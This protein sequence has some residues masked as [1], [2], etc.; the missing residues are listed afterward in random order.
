MRSPRSMRS[1]IAQAVGINGMAQDRRRPKNVTNSG[2]LTHGQRA[3]RRT[4]MRENARA[5][6]LPDPSDADYAAAGVGRRLGSY[7]QS[8]E[9]TLEKIRVA[10]AAKAQEQ[11]RLRL[12]GVCLMELG[13]QRDPNWRC[14]ISRC[15]G[16]F[17]KSE[18][19]Q[20]EQAHAS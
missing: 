18:L 6:G 5:A 20:Q 13:D 3:Y 7:E 17:T 8:K 11:A 2:E 1:A 14:A 10:N 16:P 15:I 4:L 19:K 12:C 9:A